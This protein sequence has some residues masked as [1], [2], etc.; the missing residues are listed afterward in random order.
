MYIGVHFYALLSPRENFPPMIRAAPLLVSLP[1]FL[2]ASSNVDM[3]RLCLAVSDDGACHKYIHS[4]ASA[5]AD[6]IYG[7]SCHLPSLPLPASLLS[8][9]IFELIAGS[10][11]ATSRWARSLVRK[12]ATINRWEA[13]ILTQSNSVRNFRILA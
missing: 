8:R 9:K 5:R 6:I 2:P 1:S 12:Q 13:L 3:K 7:T 11:N 10:L 4:V